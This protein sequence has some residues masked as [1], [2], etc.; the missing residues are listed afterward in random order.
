MSDQDHSPASTFDAVGLGAVLRRIA[1]AMQTGAAELN[2]AD[3]T[4]GDGDLGITVSRGFAEAAGQVLPDDLGAAFLDC[5]KAF[6]RASSSSFGTLTATAFMAV[7]KETR[8]RQQV[9]TSEVSRLT[10]SA[11]AAMMAR[12]RGQLGDKTVL[13]VMD[14]V[15]TATKDAPPEEI[16]T[17][18]RDAASVTL[19]SFRS[20]PN[21]LG[22][23]RMFGDASIDVY[24][25]GQLAAV[26]ILEAMQPD[27]SP[28]AA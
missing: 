11:L 22:R 14:A 23:A 24:D 3:G 19:E 15:A 27:M 4:L 10:A 8:G 18:A 7:A 26:R 12:G 21:K 20:R 28:P 13:D 5:A 6:Q 1:D 2:A 17:R 16:Y 25:P 9:E